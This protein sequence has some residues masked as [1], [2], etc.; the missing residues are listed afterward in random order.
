MLEM[1]PGRPEGVP[2]QK[3]LWKAAF[4]DEDRYIDWFYE[5]CGAS[6]DVLEVVEEGRLA[7]MLALLPQTLTLPGGGTASG[8]YIYALATDPGARSK[9][10]GRQLLRFVDGYLAERGAD[11][12]TT[13]PAE[14][15]LFKFFGTVGFAPCFSTRKLELLKSMLQPAA[16]G[17]RAEPVEPGEYNAIRRRLLEGAP[18]VDYPEEL[19]RYQQ[20]MGRLSG[21]GLYRLSV[22]GAEGCAAAHAEIE[23]ITQACRRLGSWRLTGCVLYVT[24]EP[25]P[26]CAGAIINARIAELRYGA[27]EEK[28]GC[29]GSVLNL[30]EE[31]F[32]HRPRIYGGLLAE[33][34]SALLREFF[35]KRR[36]KDETVV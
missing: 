9:G 25:C 31:R 26:M 1:R 36:E 4:G 32:N 17:D 19:I 10:Y 20:G 21:G 11:C 3:A 6:A 28:S 12:V 7:S 24:L 22:D 33:E 34:S 16:E 29:C 18:A 2:A 35:Q 30:F 8:W 14:P 27:R 13:V 5:C 15:S 23:A